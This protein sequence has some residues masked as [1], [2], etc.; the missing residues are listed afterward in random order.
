MCECVSRPSSPT[1]SV[2]YSL[3]VVVEG[4]GVGN[5]GCV[6]CFDVHGE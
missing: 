6:V 5:G 3:D 4:S 1:D 2:S